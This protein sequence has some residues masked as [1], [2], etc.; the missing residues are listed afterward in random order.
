LEIDFIIYGENNFWAIEVKNSSVI[1]PHDLRGLRE[2]CHDYP[3]AKPLLLYR[4]KEQL[5]KG[6]I[7]CVPVTDFLKQLKPGQRDV[8]T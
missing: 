2:F 7:L 6:N 5:Q 4:G 1:H 3:E 8:L